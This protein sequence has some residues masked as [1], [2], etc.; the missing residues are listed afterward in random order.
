MD[1]SFENFDVIF[2]N[3]FG[4][5]DSC[6]NVDFIEKMVKEIPADE[7]LKT[8]DHFIDEFFAG[9]A[10]DVTQI[11][12]TAY[13]NFQ[14]D[15]SA[16]SYELFS[17]EVPLNINSTNPNRSEKFLCFDAIKMDHNYQFTDMTR[18]R[19]LINL[20]GQVKE[21]ELYYGSRYQYTEPQEVIYNPAEPITIPKKSL[22]RVKNRRS[23]TNASSAPEKITVGAQRQNNNYAHGISDNNNDH[24]STFDPTT[25][26][27]MMLNSSFAESHNTNCDSQ[28][29][30][31]K[32]KPKLTKKS[33][34]SKSNILQKNSIPSTNNRKFSTAYTS[35]P[36][37]K[38]IMEQP[39]VDSVDHHID[40]TRKSL[41][42]RNE[43]LYFNYQLSTAKNLMYGL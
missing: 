42:Y 5:M 6:L 2:G 14:T 26:Y 1:N 36:N 16:Y 31:T 13:T 33:K 17:E 34:Q 10:N 30:P 19:S 4:D 8:T 15:K 28:S 12:D 25:S 27:G 22:K 23:N 38:R 41:E 40:V 20:P 43:Q 9:I 37:V 18:P 11:E 35:S 21:S 39:K 24:L 3:C 32:R 7:G 29:Y